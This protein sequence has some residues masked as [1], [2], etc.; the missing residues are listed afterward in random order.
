[1]NRSS[2]YLHSSKNCR[3]Y[4][5]NR[6]PLTH[7]IDNQNIQQRLAKQSTY[8]KHFKYPL[9]FLLTFV[10]INTVFFQ[11]HIYLY[12]SLYGPFHRNLDEFIEDVKNYQNGQSQ[13]WKKE[14]I[15]I[16]LDENNIQNSANKYDSIKKYSD[17]LTQ[18]YHIATYKKAKH[19]Y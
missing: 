18:G 15:Q 1:M 3:L 7:L 2:F 17:S 12:N 13:F 11:T 19:L 14:Y 5:P 6:Y 16:E 10:L 9:I 8:V 4:L